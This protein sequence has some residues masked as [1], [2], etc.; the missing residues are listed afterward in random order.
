MI[1]N[2]DRTLHASRLRA[3]SL[4]LVEVTVPLGHER[5][6]ISLEDLDGYLHAWL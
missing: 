4:R 6:P 3:E 2:P 5:A 1:E